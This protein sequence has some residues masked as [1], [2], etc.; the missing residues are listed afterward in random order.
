MAAI[1][2]QTRED[3]LLGALAPLGLAAAAGTALVVDLDPAGPSYPG[4]GSLAQLVA[5]QPRRQDLEPTRSGLAVL[6]NGGIEYS[7]AFKVV[8]ALIHGWPAVVLRLASGSGPPS[9]LT[10]LTVLPLVP[11]GLFEPVEAVEAPA[12]YQPMGFR[13]ASPPAGMMLPPFPRRV[14]AALLGGNVPRRSR[15]IRAWG[16]LWD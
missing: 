16:S 12:V 7:E 2:I 14:A 1:A 9:E 3:G 10:A 4:T 11:G 13:M 5:D 15:W 6:R 8:A